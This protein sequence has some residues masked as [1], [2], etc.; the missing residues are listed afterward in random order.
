MKRTVRASRRGLAALAGLLLAAPTLVPTAVAAPAPVCGDV[1]HQNACGSAQIC[2]CCSDPDCFNPNYGDDH[3]NCVWWAWEM[4]C[5]EWGEALSTCHNADTW[6][7]NNQATH[8]ISTEACVNTIFVCEQ[9]NAICGSTN[10]GHVGWV[11][12][13]YPDG[14]IR[15]SEQGC[16]WFRGVRERTFNAHLASPTMEY[17]YQQGLNSCSQC[18]CDPDDTE[19]RP[20]TDGCGT[21]ERTCASDCTWGAWAGCD[22]VPE[23]D[24]GESRNC[25]QCGVQICLFDCAWSACDERCDPDGGVPGPDAGSSDPDGGSQ[26]GTM[27]GGCSCRSAGGASGAAVV[28]LLVLLLTLGAWR[29]RRGSTRGRPDGGAGC[30]VAVLV[31]LVVG[32]G[33]GD[34]T[35]T[36]PDATPDDSGT[37]G[38]DA[39]SGDGGVPCVPVTIAFTDA[40]ELLVIP[41]GA[42]FMH[43]KLWGAGGNDE[44]QCDW[45]TGGAGL[46]GGQGGFTEAI[47]EVHPD[48]ALE[49][50]TALVVI[51]GAAGLAGEAASRFG[52]GVRG[53]GGL[54]GIF[55]GPGP[56]E[57]GDA[58]RAL[59]VAGGGGS[60]SGPEC[61][62]G[63]PGNHPD[64]GGRN[65]MQGGAGTSTTPSVGGG[66]GYTGGAG[67]DSREAAM[68][69]EGF[70]DV[71]LALDSRVHYASLGDYPVPGSGD[72]DYLAHGS[73]AGLSE[74]PGLAI[75]NFVC[76]AP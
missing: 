65:D 41:E 43:V 52:F 37:P 40:E 22:A 10:W 20:C 13:V 53:G 17:I 44:S 38:A 73:S 32:V 14:S 15:V 33:C 39:W 25:G 30:W 11:L 54:T 45:T 21:E 27:N 8:H 57:S 49:S 74:H 2:I 36:R 72:E 59:A 35:P 3:G 75:I 61:H 29:R 56:I 16:C 69:G 67:G 42:H 6:D 68:G 64:A 5:R 62:A 34:S 24:P 70:A 26:N 7:D 48:T 58:T 18:D 19:Q 46:D 23:C 66:A 60:A 47:F 12:E 71:D 4:A 51:V 63:G 50:G 28:L 31:A 9:D 55:F 76:P 1:S